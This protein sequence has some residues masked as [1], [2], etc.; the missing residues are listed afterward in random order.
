MIVLAGANPAETMPPL[1]GHLTAR[2][3]RLIVVD[4]RRT[5]TARRR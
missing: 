2:A 3:P 1:M 4:P 5:P